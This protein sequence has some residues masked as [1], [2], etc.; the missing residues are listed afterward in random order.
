KKSVVDRIAR[1]SR[2]L[3]AAASSP[4]S[5]PTR[6]S[7]AEVGGVAGSVACGAGTGARGAVVVAAALG[8]TVL[9]GPAAVL[10]PAA[11]P[12]SPV[13]LVPVTAGARFRP[14]S[15]RPRTAS[16]SSPAGILQ[17]QPPPWAKLVNRIGS[18]SRPYP[19]PHTPA[20]AA[21][22]PN[23]ATKSA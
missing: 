8:P 3:T 5:R 1:S 15:R 20:S 19:R 23:G 9:F 13:S 21:E 18:I 14:A 6:T 16:S 4:S 17:A 22:P 12:V 10:G 7:A 2:I 11:V